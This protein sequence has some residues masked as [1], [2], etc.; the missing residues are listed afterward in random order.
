MLALV[1]AHRLPHLPGL[2]T[3]TPRTETTRSIASLARNAGVRQCRYPRLHARELVL[4]VPLLRVP[5][6]LAL[7]AIVDLPTVESNSFLLL[8]CCYS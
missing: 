3:T 2:S 7:A 6:A 5:L 1:L 8:I 4:L